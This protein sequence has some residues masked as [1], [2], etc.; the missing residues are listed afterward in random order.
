MTSI[1]LVWRV[2]RRY[3]APV[4]DVEVD[5]PLSVT[6][7]DTYVAT[8][9]PQPLTDSIVSPITGR[10]IS[11]VLE[12]PRVTVDWGDGTV[13][14]VAA[15]SLHRLGGHPDG[16]MRHIYD[17]R[18]LYS[19]VVTYE[20]VARWRIEDGPWQNLAIDPASRVVP[21]RVD[22]LVARRVG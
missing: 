3:P 10:R 6:G 18:G 13:D 4:P 21:L 9:P 8:S 20:R 7:L 11:V 1:E 12:V 2:V 17:T 19:V 14:G 22:E 16:S 15:E 5:P